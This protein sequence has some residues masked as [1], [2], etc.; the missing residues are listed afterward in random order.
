VAGAPAASTASR[1]GPRRCDQSAR[2]RTP[3]AARCITSA[4]QSVS[5]ALKSAGEA[6]VRRAETSAPDSHASASMSPLASGSAGRQ[7]IT[8]AANTP[9][10]S[11]HSLVYSARP[12][13][14]R[15]IA[16]S[17][18]PTP[19]APPPAARSAATPAIR[20]WARPGI[21]GAVRRVSVWPRA[22]S[23]IRTIRVQNRALSAVRGPRLD[24]EG[25]PETEME[26]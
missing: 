14:Q 10:N 9:R 21:A 20:S 23:V 25:S 13:R 3:T 15:P 6:N 8:L 17:P 26:Q 18:R 5:W 2:T 19:A 4:S 12:A 16:P 1:P 24:R 22:A 11:W 7:M